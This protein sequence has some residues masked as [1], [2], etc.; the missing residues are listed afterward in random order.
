M[1][2]RAGTHLP[3]S[4]SS[5]G[6]ARR[7]VHDILVQWDREELTELA[8]LLANELVTNS[9]LHAGTDVELSVSLDEN[10]LRVEVRD[11]NPQAPRRKD[12]SL[13][14]TT[15]R[16]LVLVEELSSDWGSEPANAGKVVWF[17]LA[18][19]AS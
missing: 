14:A 1:N 18:S 12:F 15:G 4:P 19:K 8:Q 3:G 13:S 7:F 5:A 2:K 9:V 11:E 17:E 10:T 16:G 6:I